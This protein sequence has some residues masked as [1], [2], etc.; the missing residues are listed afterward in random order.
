MSQLI[1]IVIFDKMYLRVGQTL[2]G[3][4]SEE[5]CK[6]MKKLKTRGWARVRTLV[7]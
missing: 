7:V 2:I 3:T 4:E 5:K 1:L 6:V